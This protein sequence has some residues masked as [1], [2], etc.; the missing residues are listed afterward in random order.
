MEENNTREISML[1]L[2]KLFRNKF[3]VLV[4]VGLIAA[5]LGGACGLLI[6]ALNITYTAELEIY[7]TPS[8]GSNRLLYDLRSGRFAEQLLLESTGLPAKELC[9]ADDYDAALALLKE[10]EEVRQKRIDKR[11][12]ISRYYTSDI[13]NRYNVLVTEY[14]EVWGRLQTYK[15]AQTDALVDESH[16]EMIRY[17]E[18][19]LME[20]EEARDDYYDTVY[21]PV[22]EEKIR[23]NIELAELTDQLTDLRKDSEEAVEKVLA[24]WRQNPDVGKMVKVI[25]SSVTYEYHMLSYFE[26]ETQDEDAENTEALHRG[27]IKI[28]IKV[29]TSS[30]PDT[31]EDGESFVQELVDCYNLRIA[32]YVES[33]LEKATGVYEAE[34][35]VISPIVEI[36]EDPD[37]MIV[38]VIKYA[39]IGGVVAAVL[40]YAVFVLRYLLD[41][42]SAESR[43]ETGV[44]KKE[45]TSK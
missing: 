8:D 19:R 15:N 9:N 21:Y 7:V 2:I 10:L 33:Y 18:D 28:K 6:T 40:A 1:D 17:Y 27:Y 37:S 3:K 26:D 20:A 30:V 22:V 29:P 39:V 11:E 13:E 38:E 31:A 34:C 43:E 45:K 16:I 36:E 35:T 44:E 32:D 12:E 41:P 25:M 4:V 42:A 23:L 5:I 14:N 24:A